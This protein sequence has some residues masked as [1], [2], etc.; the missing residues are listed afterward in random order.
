MKMPETLMDFVSFYDDETVDSFV[1]CKLIK[2]KTRVIGFVAFS[3]FFEYVIVLDHDNGD[4][5]SLEFYRPFIP[6]ETNRLIGTLKEK[7]AFTDYVI[8]EICNVSAPHV[9]KKLKLWNKQKLL[10]KEVNREMPTYK[11]NKEDRHHG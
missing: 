5:T 7:Y 1:S 11:I 9:N 3:I 6:E 10:L 4:Y 2:S 8:A